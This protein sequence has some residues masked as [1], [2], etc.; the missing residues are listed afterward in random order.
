MGLDSS[1]KDKSGLYV[2]DLDLIL[3]YHW[4]L[5]DGIFAHERL[6]VQMAPILI[7]AGTTS[8]RPGILIGKLQYKDVQF[9]M[10]PPSPGSKRARVGMVVI[11][12]KTKRTAGQSRPKKYGFYE[13]DTL[14]R[15]P[16]L[17]I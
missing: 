15:D 10:F 7:L 12:T 13:E 5:D 9:H 14:L 3:H 8:T 11:L 1:T 4:I 2:E 6:C 17:Y 16:V